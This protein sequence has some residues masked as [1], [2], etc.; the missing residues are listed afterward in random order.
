MSLQ[1]TPLRE[2]L[3]RIEAWQ[4]VQKTHPP[5]SLEWRHASDTL[6]PL[7]REMQP[8]QRAGEPTSC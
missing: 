2:L 3:A 5:T 1:E 8:R 7:F 4:H 6:Q